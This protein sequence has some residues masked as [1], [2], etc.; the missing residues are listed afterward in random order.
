MSERSSTAALRTTTRATLPDAEGLRDQARA[1][2][3]KALSRLDELL[4]RLAAR[5]EARGGHVFWAS[6]GGAARQYIADL[7]RARGARLIVKSKSMASEEIHLN[8]AL[9]GAGLEVV[10]TDLG[11]Y[12]IQLADETPSH[13]IA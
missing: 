4:E 10:E 9:E 1:V 2:R 11:E 7:A 6:D 8:D 12:I 5:I 3:A 13:I